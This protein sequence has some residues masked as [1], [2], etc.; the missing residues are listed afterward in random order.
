MREVLGQERRLDFLAALP[1][2]A[3]SQL[4]KDILAARQRQKKALEEAV[5]HGLRMVPALLRGPIKKI[6]F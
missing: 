3:Q 5:D 2:S 1:E 6:L 4:S